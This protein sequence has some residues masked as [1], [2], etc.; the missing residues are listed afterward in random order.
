MS[1]RKL[2]AEE[3]AEILKT[4]MLTK[5]AIVTGETW[6]I[7]PAEVLAINFFQNSRPPE[8]PEDPRPVPVRQPRILQLKPERRTA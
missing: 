5:S 2:T 8:G 6:D 3:K 4:F 1:Y 7:D